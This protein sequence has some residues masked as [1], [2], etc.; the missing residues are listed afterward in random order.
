MASKL[1][2]E[3]EDGN[4]AALHRGTS[5]HFDTLFAIRRAR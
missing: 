2:I 4:E 3:T 5:A 1:K